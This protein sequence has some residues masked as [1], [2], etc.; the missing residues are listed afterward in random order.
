MKHLL[1]ICTTKIPFRNLDG[2][3]FVQKEGVSMGSALVSTFANFYMCHLENKLLKGTR[4]PKPLLYIRYVYDICVVVNNF[5][6]LVM[7]KQALEDKSELKFTFETEDKKS[8][9]AYPGNCQWGG[10][11]GHFSTFSSKVVKKN[12]F[13][14]L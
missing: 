8:T 12:Q 2:D 4:I 3:L 9:G 11:G 7:L 5:E 10:G 14:Y 1:E 6:C 13:S